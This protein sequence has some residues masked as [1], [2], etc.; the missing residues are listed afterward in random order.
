M[1]GQV[2]YDR[3][4]SCRLFSHMRVYVCLD[5]HDVDRCITS[6]CAACYRTLVWD[7]CLALSLHGVAMLLAKCLHIYMAC[8]PESALEHVCECMRKLLSSCEVFS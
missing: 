6:S 3:R 1:C 2:I 5:V 4:T 8:M 7:R